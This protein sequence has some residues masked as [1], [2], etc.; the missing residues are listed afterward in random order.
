MRSF[1][2]LIF[3]FFAYFSLFI[4]L[5]AAQVNPALTPQ[6]AP[7]PTLPKIDEKACPFEG[8][9]FG[10]WTAQET[11]ELFSTWKPGR[12]PVANIAK[13]KEVTALTGV[14][15]TYEAE[16][17]EI[18]API[19]QYGLKPGDKVS[20][21]MNLGEGF[22]NAWFNGTWVEDFDASGIRRGEEGC[23]R[24]CS[25]KQVK[26]GRYEWWVQMRT[27]DGVVGWTQET[28]KFSGK[29]SLAGEVAVRRRL[30]A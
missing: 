26:P 4:V 20:G 17:I 25:G 11:V 6:K 14:H 21:Y 23:M 30:S 18:T 16:E 5:C 9:Q 22:M 15:I 10:K 13:G 19:A 8:C 27:K 24:D 2:R 12:A 29:D 1:L 7:K 28:D 3:F